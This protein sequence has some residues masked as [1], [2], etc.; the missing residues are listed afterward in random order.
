MSTELVLNE[1]ATSR[2]LSKPMTE[3]ATYND[4]T[5][6]ATQ[7]QGSQFLPD[8]LA[9]IPTLASVL[10][11]GKELNMTPM[12][13]CQNII[14]INGKL[15]LTAAAMA[16]L[17]RQN[18]VRYTLD[19]DKVPVYGD[20]WVDPHDTNKGTTQG[21]IDYRST[22]TFMEMWHGQIIK[23]TISLT[24]QEAVVIATDNGRRDL[25]GTYIKYARN[26]MTARL[27]TRG[28]RLACPE[29]LLGGGAL[30]T[31]EEIMMDAGETLSEEQM[32]NML[33]EEDGFTVE[34]EVIEI[35]EDD[36]MG[37]R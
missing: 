23:N 22:M 16:A 12:S 8:H 14:N 15:T 35:V 36:E 27:L 25:P 26:M 20:V 29:A 2:A 5:A 30:Y 28:V 3:L 4:F 7:L 11:M 13:A 19:E 10:M 24:W 1:Q 18:G 34:G 32:K 9:D 37:S 31:P 17:L 21:I 33:N 6:I